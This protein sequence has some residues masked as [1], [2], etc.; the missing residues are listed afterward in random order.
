MSLVNKVGEDI[1]LIIYHVIG[2]VLIYLSHTRSDIAHAVSLVSQLMHNPSEEHMGV[3]TRILQYLKSSSGKGLMCKKYSHLNINGC[4]DADWAGSATDRR[5]T[6]GY[7]TFAGGNLVTWR[8]KKQKVVALS[9][10]E[11][12]FRSMTKKFVN[13]FG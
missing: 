11:A 5:S 10:T 3:V 13:F 2:V 12:K 9:S 4:I 6:S 7:L 8:S 1:T